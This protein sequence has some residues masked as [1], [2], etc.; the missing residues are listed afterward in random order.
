MEK[1][2]VR[3]YICTAADNVRRKHE[4]IVFCVLTFAA[5]PIKRFTLLKFRSSLFKG[6]QIPKTAS[7]VAVRRRRNTLALSPLKEGTLW[8]KAFPKKVLLNVF[9]Y[10]YII[11]NLRENSAGLPTGFFLLENI[12]F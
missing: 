9:N 1:S 10:E 11:K 6:W 3:F 2:N 8:Q 5:R 4:K 12:R 7:L